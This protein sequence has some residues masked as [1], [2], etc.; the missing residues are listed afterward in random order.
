MPDRFPS[1]NTSGCKS[2][3][4][5][6]GAW[7]QWPSYFP[8]GLL[9]S[10]YIQIRICGEYIQSVKKKKSH[11]GSVILHMFIV[12][13]CSLGGFF[14]QIFFPD[15][16]RKMQQFSFQSCFGDEKVINKLVLNHME[17]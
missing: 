8:S 9:Q 12:V 15:S 7:F 4:S 5:G 14:G 2:F 6:A 10:K 17:I 11:R 3:S 1:T 16:S 13:M